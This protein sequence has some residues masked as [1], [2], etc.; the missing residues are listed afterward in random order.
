[1]RDLATDIGRVDAWTVLERQLRILQ[2][3]DFDLSWPL[4]RDAAVTWHL[5]SSSARCEPS[6][7]DTRAAFGWDDMPHVRRAA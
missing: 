4:V 5:A 3:D 6:Q 1:M 2:I 7:C